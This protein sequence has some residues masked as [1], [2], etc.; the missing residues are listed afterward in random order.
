MG[1]LI[2]EYPPVAARPTNTPLS[3]FPGPL[4]TFVFIPPSPAFLLPL[5]TS[6]CAHADSACRGVGAEDLKQWDLE[7]T[8][9][10]SAMADAA[11]CD[12]TAGDVALLKF[13][14]SAA[15]HPNLAVAA[16]GNAH[17]RQPPFGPFAPTPHMYIEFLALCPSPLPPSPLE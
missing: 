12:F 11:A 10:V 14:I 9:D 3:P 16:M 1:R 5:S 13:V 17:R 15:L 2:A 6:S 4:L 7:L 8:V